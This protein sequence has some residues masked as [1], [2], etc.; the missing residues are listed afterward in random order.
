[1]AEK[2]FNRLVVAQKDIQD[3]IKNFEGASNISEED[4]FDGDYFLDGINKSLRK[5]KNLSQ[6]Y[7]SEGT[8]STSDN[9]KSPTK[10]EG[11]PSNWCPETPKLE[12]DDVKTKGD[13]VAIEE[14]RR[15]DE[16]DYAEQSKVSL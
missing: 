5:L 8:G 14:G 9:S 12:K 4:L 15:V 1:M 10:P 11:E 3:I 16:I 13:E 2:F 7:K 6:N